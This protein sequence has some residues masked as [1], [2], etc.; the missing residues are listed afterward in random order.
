M[1]VVERTALSI[2]A[3]S[4]GEQPLPECPACLPDID[5]A[6][7]STTFASNPVDAG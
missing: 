1:R 2:N 7:S 6:V 3:G 4:E 5:E